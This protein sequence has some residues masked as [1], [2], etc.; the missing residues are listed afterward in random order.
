MAS[1][2][3]DQVGRVASASQGSV[4]TSFDLPK[5]GNSAA[6]EFWNRTNC[7]MQVWLML[8]PYRLGGRIYLS[9]HSHPWG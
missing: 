9:N 6:A 1:L 7:G 3:I 5:S 8:A 2:P 4:S